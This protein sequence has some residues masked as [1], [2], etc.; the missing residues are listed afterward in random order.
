MKLRPEDDHGGTQGSPVGPFLYASWTPTID[1]LRSGKARL[2]LPSVLF[3]EP[4]ER[5]E[6]A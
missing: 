3:G 5:S 1:G 6:G 2:R 4:T